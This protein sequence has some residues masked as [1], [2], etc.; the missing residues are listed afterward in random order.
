MAG[1]FDSGTLKLFDRMAAS[2]RTSEADIIGVSIMPLDG[3]FSEESEAVTATL[4][5]NVTVLGL[6]PNALVADA[7]AGPAQYSVAFAPETELTIG[8]TLV[9]RIALHGAI[10]TRRVR[11]TGTSGPATIMVQRVYRCQDDVVGP[12]AV[13]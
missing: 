12:A 10:L 2:A 7:P 3:G 4:P 9:L 8:T 5:C 6:S 1:L 13:N 11:V